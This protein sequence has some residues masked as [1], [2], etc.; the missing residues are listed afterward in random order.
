MHLTI[1]R[2]GSPTLIPV[3]RRGSIEIRFG[4]PIRFAPD[5]PYD[6]ATRI[7]EDAVKAL[8]D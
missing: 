1:H 3:R 6:E 5:T 8:G 4:E 2:L 7:I